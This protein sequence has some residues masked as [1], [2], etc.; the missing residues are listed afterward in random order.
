MGPRGSASELEGTSVGVVC[1]TP[2]NLNSRLDTLRS[3]CPVEVIAEARICT[4]LY[5][6]RPGQ[7]LSP[8]ADFQATTTDK[9]TPQD[10]LRINAAQGGNGLST[11]KLR[12]ALKSGRGVSQRR[13]STS[14]R[15]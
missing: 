11:E 12:K 7:L 3:R 14:V 9:G 1:L 13:S 2:E 10:A 15:N 8:L 6:L 5:E 4:Y